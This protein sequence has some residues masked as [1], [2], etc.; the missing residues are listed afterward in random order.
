MIETAER[1]ECQCE[2]CKNACKSCPGWF[3]P[4]EAE[5]AATHMG[6]SLQDFFDKYLG[7][8]WWEGDDPIFVLA[9]ALVGEDTGTEYPGDPRGTCVFFNKDGLCDIHKVKPYEC[10]ELL[11]DDPNAQK[12]HEFI[13]TQWEVHQ[14]QISELLGREPETEEF[15]GGGLFGGLFGW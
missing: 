14:D 6:L 1:I 5:A 7:V 4:G 9:P 2:H 10:A 8:N 15:Y 3:L 11:C 12:R 13:A